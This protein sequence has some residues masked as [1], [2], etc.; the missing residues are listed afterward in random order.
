MFNFSKTIRVK[1]VTQKYNPL[2]FMMNVSKH[3]LLQHVLILE[4]DS[5]AER[6]DTFY[7]NKF[8][9]YSI[10]KPFSSYVASYNPTYKEVPITFVIWVAVTIVALDPYLRQQCYTY[11]SASNNTMPTFVVNLFSY[12][13]K[14]NSNDNVITPVLCDLYLNYIKSHE[15]EDTIWNPDY[16]KKNQNELFDLFSFL[17][18]PG[19]SDYGY[20]LSI[21]D[22]PQ[23]IVTGHSLLSSLDVSLSGDIHNVRSAAF[24]TFP[25]KDGVIQIDEV[26]A[27]YAVFFKTRIFAQNGL[28]YSFDS[29]ANYLEVLVNPTLILNAIFKSTKENTKGRRDNNHARNNVNNDEDQS[30]P[31]KSLLFKN[32]QPVL[33]TINLVAKLGDRRLLSQT[34]RLLHRLA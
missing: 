7:R 4:K 26:S 23:F 30:Q 19:F 5:F 8:I 18:S 10:F 33:E 3:D 31:Q 34:L 28:A 21:F 11:F 20:K 13:R 29:A 25:K 12:I 15:L 6:K 16:L 17:V 22:K 14:N 24:N 32:V 1:E 27:T 9:N 2:W